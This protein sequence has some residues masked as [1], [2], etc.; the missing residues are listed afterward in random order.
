MTRKSYFISLKL[1]LGWKCW[2]FF[3]VK[4]KILFMQFSDVQFL[5]SIS[6]FDSR[7]LTVIFV[8][9]DKF[10]LNITYINLV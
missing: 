4:W 6:I 1:V 10:L 7:A 3:H 5:L 9:S 8:I 2:D